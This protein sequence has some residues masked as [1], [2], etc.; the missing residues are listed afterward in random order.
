MFDVIRSGNIDKIRSGLLDQ[1]DE[2]SGEK[3]AEDM[4]ANA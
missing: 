2:H 3:H 1:R 4:Q